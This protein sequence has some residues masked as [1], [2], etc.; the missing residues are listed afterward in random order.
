MGCCPNSWIVQE[1]QL[2]LQ[3]Y[4]AEFCY[5]TLMIVNLDHS[6]NLVSASFLHYKGIDFSF[7]IILWGRYL[8]IMQIF[9]WHLIY[10]I[11]HHTFIHKFWHPLMTLV[12]NNYYCDVCLL[13]EFLFPSFLQHFLLEFYSNKELSLLP[14]LLIYSITCLYWHE[15]MDIFAPRGYN[16]FLFCCSNC[17]WFGHWD[18]FVNTLIRLP[19]EL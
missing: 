15:L 19:S 5:L 9:W 16:A 1:S 11:S 6:V 17:L 7:I 4:S 14:H 10:E 12:C 3:I 13:V 18:S 8:E 2:D